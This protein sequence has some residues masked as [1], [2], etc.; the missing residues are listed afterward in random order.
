M[1]PGRYSY[2]S[3]AVRVH[4]ASLPV[5]DG[6]DYI[7]RAD[8]LVHSVHYEIQAVSCAAQHLRAD[9]VDR[10]LLAIDEATL[11]HALTLLVIPRRSL[12]DRRC[13]DRPDACCILSTARLLAKGGLPGQNDEQAGKGTE[14]KQLTRGARSGK[15]KRW[16][17]CHR[18]RTSPSWCRRQTRSWAREAEGCHF[19]RR[20]TRRPA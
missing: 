9:I 10:P 19:V 17:R 16:T 13:K 7:A 3:T 18:R 2:Q 8:T 20:R 5:T 15:Q 4:E 6:G 1:I 11:S 12:H 14:Q